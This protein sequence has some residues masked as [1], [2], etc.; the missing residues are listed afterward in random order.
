MS[1]IPGTSK[2]VVPDPGTLVVEN[3]DSA[4]EIAVRSTY[5]LSPAMEEEHRD[6]ARRGHLALDLELENY[7]DFANLPDR[8]FVPLL[9]GEYEHEGLDLSETHDRTLRGFIVRNLLRAEIMDIQMNSLLGLPNHVQTNAGQG[10]T[11]ERLLIRYQYLADS[12]ANR[13]ALFPQLNQAPSEE[14]NLTRLISPQ[15]FFREPEPEEAENEAVNEAENEAEPVPDPVQ[16]ECTRDLCICPGPGPAQCVWE[17]YDDEP[18]AE[19]ANGNDET[20]NRAIGQDIVT[21]QLAAVGVNNFA[22]MYGNGNGYMQ[23]NSSFEFEFDSQT[24]AENSFEAH[25]ITS[26]PEMDFPPP[27]RHDPFYFDKDEYR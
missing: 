17:R 1:P 26:H 16:E 20:E 15:Y 19:I 11:W 21:E 6:H 7:P 24:E 3:S 27:N 14:N 9:F 12:M 10:R 4:R 8:P 25:G 5:N 2:E 22:I 18:E 23:G 13:E